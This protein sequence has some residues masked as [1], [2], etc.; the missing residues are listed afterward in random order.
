MTM[1][2]IIIGVWLC[3]AGIMGAMYTAY[4]ISQQWR[5]L[6]ILLALGIAGAIFL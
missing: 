1:A 5:A 2:N 4:L 6:V 3:A